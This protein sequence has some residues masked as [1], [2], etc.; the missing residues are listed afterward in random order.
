MEL[1]PEGLEAEIIVGADEAGRGALAGPIVG[2]AVAVSSR[3]EQICEMAADS[4]TLDHR[5]RKLQLPEIIKI[6]AAVSVVAASACDIDRK[7][8]QNCNKYVL[9]KSVSN[10]LKVLGE[11]S[12]HR[13]A[14]IIDHVSLEQSSFL[15]DVAVVSVP[16]ADSSYAAV[17][18]A[19]VLAKYTRD[20]VVESCQELY[21]GYNFRKHRGYGTREHLAEIKACGASDIH[22]MSFK[23]VASQKLF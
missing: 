22:R 17:A 7:G 2:A 13:I 11:R 16:R 21:P 5:L 12:K 1:L 20:L 9:E 14:V 10:V 19:S 3:S 4:K 6:A 23:P 18:M 8:L 15:P